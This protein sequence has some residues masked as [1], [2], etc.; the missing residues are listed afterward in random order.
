MTTYIALIRGIN[1]G[2]NNMVAMADLR[3][4]AAKIG[5]VGAQTLLQ[6]GNMVFQSALR[7][8]DSVEQLLEAEAKKRLK[9]ESEFHVR[10]AAEWQDAIKRNPFAEAAK[11]DPGHTIVS[12]FKV[13]PSAKG[14]SALQAA[15]KGPELV[16]A[17]GRQAYF[18]YPEGMGRSKVTPA[19]VDKHLGRGTARNW[20]TTMKLAALAASL[21]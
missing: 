14:V 9:L 20:N 15:I 5:L 21:E 7:T 18:V 8:A 12:F 11:T 3:A 17:F 1:V 6:S 13:A 16:R 4:F 10:T 2:G 19:M